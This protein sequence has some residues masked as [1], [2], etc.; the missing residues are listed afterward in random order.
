MEEGSGSK[1]KASLR[2]E[3]AE[4]SLAPEFEEFEMEMHAF[5]AQMLE[6]MQKLYVKVDN[7][8]TRLLFV[9]NKMRDMK[10]EMRL[11]KEG[12]EEWEE[13]EESEEESEE[14]NEEEK[15]VEEQGE[16]EVVQEKREEKQEKEGADQEKDESDKGDSFETEFYHP[17]TKLQTTGSKYKLRQRGPTKF[18]NTAEKTLELTL[19]PSPSPSPSTSIHVS[20]P[21]VSL[22]HTS[23]PPPTTLPPSIH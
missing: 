12:K 1:G 2:S 7:V 19:S 23:P 22:P 18:S 14:E 9:E 6:L 11:I 4:K 5:M 15:G 10:K 3:S 21:R 8:A 13:E 20:S 17:P 16:K